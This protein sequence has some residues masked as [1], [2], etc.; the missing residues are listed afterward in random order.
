MS[1]WGLDFVSGQFGRASCSDKPKNIGYTRLN[2]IY[3][4]KRKCQRSDFFHTIKLAK[5][6]LIPIIKSPIVGV[7]LPLS[8]I[9]GLVAL[10]VAD[11][12]AFGE[13]VGEAFGVADADAEGL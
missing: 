10:A 12:E 5:S 9:G 13:A 4:I 2:R 3:R 8:G 11:A 7:K 6:R 1:Y